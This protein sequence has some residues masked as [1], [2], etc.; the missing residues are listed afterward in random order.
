MVA[1]RVTSQ[2]HG[3]RVAFAIVTA[4]GASGGNIDRRGSSGRINVGGPSRLLKNTL[5]RRAAEI[6]REKR[7]PAR[8][9]KILHEEVCSAFLSLFSASL[10]FGFLLFFFFS[11]LLNPL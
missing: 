4:A 6:R 2:F 9:V 7:G 1:N 5:N 11:N 10:R 3:V 8:A